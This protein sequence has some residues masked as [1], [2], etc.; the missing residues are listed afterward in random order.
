MET[1][2]EIKNAAVTST[3]MALP[4]KRRRIKYMTNVMAMPVT[5]TPPRRGSMLSWSCSD[6]MAMRAVFSTK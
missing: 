6:S 5:V 2:I 4:S 1:G 3:R